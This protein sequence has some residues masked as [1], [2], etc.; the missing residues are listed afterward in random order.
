[1]SSSHVSS[2]S[3]DKQ[4]SFRA[5]INAVYSRSLVAHVPPASPRHPLSVPP[6][7]RPGGA[8]PQAHALQEQPGLDGEVRGH[9]VVQRADREP[10]RRAE[11]R[12]LSQ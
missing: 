8:A 7:P 12:A 10:H 6:V 9:E 4:S 3:S 1:M 11:E 2:A 5:R